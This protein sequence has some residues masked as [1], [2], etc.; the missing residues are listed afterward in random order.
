MW[1][2]EMRLIRYLISYHSSLDEGSLLNKGYGEKKLGISRILPFTMASSSVP[3][4][5]TQSSCSCE[6]LEKVVKK[7]E[8]QLLQL[9]PVNV[10]EVQ[11]SGQS[12]LV[13]HYYWLDGGMTIPDSYILTWETGTIQTIRFDF[14]TG[15]ETYNGNLELMESFSVHESSQEL[16]GTNCVDVN[17]ALQRT[18]E[19]LGQAVITDPTA[20]FRGDFH[21][22]ARG[23]TIEVDTIPNG[24]PISPITTDLDDTFY[25]PYRVQRFDDELVVRFYTKECNGSNGKNRTKAIAQALFKLGGFLLKCAAI[26]Q[27]NGSYELEFPKRAS[28]LQKQRF[29]EKLYSVLEKNVLLY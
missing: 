24:S 15:N 22:P 29:K 8:K 17:G 26:R 4:A 3:E 18:G 2:I 28:E 1:Y 21:L 20:D 23:R 6:E 25:Y 16:L 14:Y 7:L 13:I 10:S 5:P 27:A 11:E 9:Q 12:R 19:H